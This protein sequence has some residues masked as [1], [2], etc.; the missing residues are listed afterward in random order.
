MCG[1]TMCEGKRGCHLG[2]LFDYPGVEL[3]GEAEESSLM[4]LAGGE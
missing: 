2:Q 1:F 4:I 3:R